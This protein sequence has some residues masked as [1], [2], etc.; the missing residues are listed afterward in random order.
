MEVLHEQGPTSGSANACTTA[1]TDDTYS[2]K[3]E[4]AEIAIHRAHQTTAISHDLQR[5]IDA[6]PA[7]PAAV[8]H[9]LLTIIDA[10]GGDPDEAPDLPP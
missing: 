5:V 9:G 2:S 6:W 1:C 8:C 4:G 3:S 10:I 7:L